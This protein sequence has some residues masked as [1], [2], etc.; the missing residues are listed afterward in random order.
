M[1]GYK[2]VEVE[3]KREVQPHWWILGAFTLGLGIIVDALTGALVD[4]TPDYIFVPLE[5]E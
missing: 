4:I 2:V 5:P 3:L 1:D